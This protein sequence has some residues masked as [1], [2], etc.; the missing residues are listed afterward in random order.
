[1]NKELLQLFNNGIN[2]G[3]I[4]IISNDDVIIKCHDFVLYRQCAYGKI[5]QQYQSTQIFGYKQITLDYPAKIVQTI[6]SRMYSDE[7]IFCNLGPWEIIELVKLADFLIIKHYDTIVSIVAKLFYRSLTNDNWIGLLEKIYG[8]N[9]FIKLQMKVLK[10][11]EKEII[12]YDNPFPDIST[13]R[14][15]IIQTLRKIYDENNKIN[16]KLDIRF[17]ITKLRQKRQK[18]LHDE[19]VNSEIEALIS[20]YRD[21]DDDIVCW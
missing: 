19:S 9:I 20:E 7:F 6:I 3:N 14:E 13:L 11:F 12:K 18:D 5:I 2:D 8:E 16:K 21:L 17:R 1:M 15:E 10:Y 4:E